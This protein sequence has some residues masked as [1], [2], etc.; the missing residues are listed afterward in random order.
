MVV[1]KDPESGWINVGTY[2]S[3]V[4]GKDRLTLWIIEQKHGKQIARRYWQAGRPCPV[5]IVLGCEPATWMAAP[6]AA[7][8]GVSEYEYAGALRGA[9][10][11]IIRAPYTGLPVPAEYQ[12]RSLAKSP[13][14]GRAISYLPYLDCRIALRDGSW[15]LIAGLDPSVNQLYDARTDPLE[16]TDVAAK[17]PEI[18]ACMRRELA[19][20]LERQNPVWRRWVE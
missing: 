6:S 10:L 17:N 13:A 4:V 5:A 3:C 15:T 7:K 2:R 18:V 20:W 12:G 16:Q 14:G 19:G 9:P 11:E 1:T 8:A